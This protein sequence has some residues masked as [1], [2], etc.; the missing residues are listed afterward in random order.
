MTRYPYA[1]HVC[2]LGILS[3]HHLFDISYAEKKSI[4]C[5]LWSQSHSDLNTIVGVEVSVV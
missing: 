2:V 5:D 4:R 3:K 1:V